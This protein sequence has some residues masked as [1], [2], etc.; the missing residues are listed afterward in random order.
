MIRFISVSLSFELQKVLIV[1]HSKWRK[2]F[3]LADEVCLI[4]AGRRSPAGPD[5][6]VV[7]GREFNNLPTHTMLVV[8]CNQVT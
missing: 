5:R 7:G 1:Y 4:I 6:V 2:I 3:D 8:V